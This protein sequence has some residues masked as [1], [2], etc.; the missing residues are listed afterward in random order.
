MSK[1]LCIMGIVV[2]VLVLLVFGLDAA[3]GFPFR[4][5]DWMLDLGFLASAAI[6]GYISWTTL[7]EQQ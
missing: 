1:G 7:K 6:L 3:I 2:A 5:G 4:R